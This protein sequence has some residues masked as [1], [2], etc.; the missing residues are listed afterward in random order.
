MKKT[1]F[2][3]LMIL[4]NLTAQQN[5]PTIG[6]QV[7]I[8]PG[9]TENSIEHWFKTLADHD[10]PVCRIRMF[11]EHLQQDFLPT[12]TADS[13]YDFSLY[14]Y[15]FDMA[16]KYNVKVFATLFPTTGANVGGFKFPRDEQHLQNISDYIQEVVTHYKDHPAMDTWVLQNEPGTG[17]FPDNE[18][19]QIKYAEWLNELP[20]PEY[21]NPFAKVS[22]H[23]ELFLREHTRWYLN[24][25]AEQ[26]RQYDTNHKT[27][28]NNHQLFELLPEYDFP[29]WM[30]FLTSLGASIHAGWHLRYFD[31]SQYAMA[32]M[33]NCDIIRDAALPKPFWVTEL[34]GGNNLFSAYQPLCP[35]KEEIDQ[36]LWGSIGSGAQGIIFWSLNPRASGAEAG[37]WAMLD[38]QGEPT[39]RLTATA[40]VAETILKDPV[41]FS[42]ATPLLS[43]IHLLYSPESMIFQ[44]KNELQTGSNEFAA[45]QKG[46][47]IKSLLAYYETLLEMGIAPH[48]QQ[49][50]A[51][52]WNY[53]GDSAKVVIL[54]NMVS[55]PSKYW[56]KLDTFVQNGNKLII[57]GLSG[58]YD[59]NMHNVYQTNDP[60]KVMLGA[61]L[62]EFKVVKNYFDLKLSDPSIIH[63]PAHLWQGT[64]QNYN[65]A[66]IGQ[67]EGEITAIRRQYGKGEVVWIPSLVGLGAWQNDN[68]PL[69]KWLDHELSIWIEKMPVRFKDHQPK[70]IMKTLHASD[71]DYCTIVINERSY[72]KRAELVIPSG[73]EPKIIHGGKSNLTLRNHTVQLAPYET[74]VIKWK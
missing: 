52:D 46:A 57:T 31:R 2:F 17:A 44:K 14:D 15:A 38:F 37:E 9:Q 73:K 18:L 67:K 60:L 74:V 11:Q 65:A 20:L 54:A 68:K 56:N 66:A 3:F 49:M 26:I 34:Q 29:Q 8:E 63:L 12:G 27:H 6:A 25:I 42:K 48:I 51:F 28:V 72:S 40:K 36:W 33:A 62:K 13:I 71:G 41:F 61:S 19:A 43:D 45:R 5:V 24:W 47:H 64:I 59:E 39:D 69:A 70:I 22:I 32:V 23:K 7:F 1:I 30:P 10:M 58:F 53:I 35:A 4:N 16:A 55:I 50:D 21:N